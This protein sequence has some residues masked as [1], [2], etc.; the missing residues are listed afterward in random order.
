MFTFASGSRHT[1]IHLVRQ[2]SHAQRFGIRRPSGQSL[3]GLA[4]RSR[5]AQPDQHTR[6]GPRLV[7]LQ[8]GVP[9]P[10]ADQ[11]ERHVVSSGRPR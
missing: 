6:I 4:V 1:D 5:F 8:G 10:V 3:A 2:L 9:Q 11:Q 7:R